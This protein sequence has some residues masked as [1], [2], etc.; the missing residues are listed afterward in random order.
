MRASAPYNSGR[1][2]FVLLKMDHIRVARGGSLSRLHWVLFPSEVTF[3]TG[4]FLFSRSKV[5]DA[6]IGIIA[7]F[8]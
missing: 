1:G 6:N 7:N 8:V 2:S 5:S 4:F 3:F